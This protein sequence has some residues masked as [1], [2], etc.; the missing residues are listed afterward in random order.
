MENNYV[1]SQRVP[2]AKGDNKQKR[3]KR[4]IFLKDTEKV[5]DEEPYT[6]VNVYTL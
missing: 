5:D 2:T 6:T 4:R 3:R 1:N